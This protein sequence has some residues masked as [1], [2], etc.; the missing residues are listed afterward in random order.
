M[1]KF[2]GNSQFFDLCL[3]LLQY[4]LMTEVHEENMASHRYLVVITHNCRYS[5]LILYQNSASGCFF[6]SYSVK[7]EI[8][9][10]N[11]SYFVTLKSIN[12]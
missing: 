4:V 3:H 7:S 9:S 6:K 5:S 8:V 1:F 10:I 12:L 11:F 2:T